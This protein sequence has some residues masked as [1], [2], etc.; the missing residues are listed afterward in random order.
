MRGLSSRICWLAVLGTLG[1]A[2]HR[3]EPA[4]HA[5]ER[6]F[7]AVAAK[8][9]ASLMALTPPSSDGTTCEAIIESFEHRGARLIAVLGSEPDGR[10]PRVTIVRT[11]VAFRGR[12]GDWLVR[13]EPRDGQW[14]LRF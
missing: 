6:Y 5:V 7:A 8:D 12:E 11:R 13:A 14:K 4:A 2:C 9:C 3:R 10:D 1:G